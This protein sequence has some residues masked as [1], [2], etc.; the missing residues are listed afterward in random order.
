MFRW[1]HKQTATLNCPLQS[2]SDGRHPMRSVFALLFASTTDAL[3]LVVTRRQLIDGAAFT[4]AASALPAFASQTQDPAN[5]GFS[6]D[7]VDAVA[8][9]G[10]GGDGP[11][12]YDEVARAQ[13]KERT[14]ASV[15]RWRKMVAD[16]IKAL[17]KPTPAY[18]VAQSALDNN[19]N[20]LKADMRAVSK[21]LSGGDITIG[22]TSPGGVKNVQFDYNSGQYKLQ[23]L[24]EQ[25]EAVFT[26]INSVYF[27]AIKPRKPA[28]VAIEGMQKASSKFD[29]WLSTAQSMQAEAAAASAPGKSGSER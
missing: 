24:A 22:Y 19:M 18:P 1:L 10:L 13:V 8:R 12:L 6:L 15:T 11:A 27:D 20:A 3:Q 29:A 17:D 16:V 23:P 5:L 4:A 7:E 9:N 21:E 25:A 2:G 26:V 28:T 14:D